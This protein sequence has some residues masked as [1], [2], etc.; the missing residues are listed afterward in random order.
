MNSAGTSDVGDG[1]PVLTSKLLAIPGELRNRIFEAV[2]LYDSSIEGRDMPRLRRQQKSI[3]ASKSRQIEDWSVLRRQTY[4]LTQV[5][6]SIRKE[7]LPLYREKV[8]VRIDIRDLPYYVTDVI[9]SNQN[10][11]AR[12]YGNISIDVQYDCSVNIQDTIL[13]HDRA[14]NLHLRFTHPGRQDNDMM[15]I[16]LDAHR[17]PKFHAYISERTSHV[18]LDIGISD[19]LVFCPGLVDD[20]E[21]DDY[22]DPPL[23]TW[24]YAFDSG[25]FAYVKGL[26]YVKEHFEE[27]WMSKSAL[28][29]EHW[30]DGLAEWEET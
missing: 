27:P 6:S 28:P 30:R 26:L 16:L 17:W 3:G 15:S 11:P 14:P 1:A 9:L 25:Y 7:L 8:A 29:A 22:W 2:L 12:V 19:A 13:L 5:S 18:V 21:L 20:Q 24:P 23:L 4:G 10:D